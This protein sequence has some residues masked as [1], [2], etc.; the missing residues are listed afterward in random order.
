MDLNR[1]RKEL[2]ELIN[3]IQSQQLLSELRSV[4]ED[5]MSASDDFELSPSHREVLDQRINKYKAGEGKL[6]SWEEV[7]DKVKG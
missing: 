1:E 5:L 2:V 3:Q 6:Y 7:V 4:V